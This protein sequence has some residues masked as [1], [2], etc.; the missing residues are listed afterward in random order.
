MFHVVVYVISAAVFPHFLY[1]KY[2]DYM[3]LGETNT[4]FGQRGLA[5]RL[6]TLRHHV[7]VYLFR[8]KYFLYHPVDESIMLK[9]LQSIATSVSVCLS[10]RSY[11]SKTTRVNFTKFS[12]HAACGQYLNIVVL[13]VLQITSF[14]L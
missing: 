6:H 9:F 1:Y 3:Y 2:F 11:I 7:K 4:E 13:L 14:C 5:S 10:V 12:I 8:Y